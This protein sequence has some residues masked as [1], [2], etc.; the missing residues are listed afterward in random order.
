[1]KSDQHRLAVLPALLLLALTAAPAGAAPAASCADAAKS[2]Q[3]DFWIGEWD[4]IAGGGN[5]GIN[6]IEPILGGCVL[7]E[8]WR[9]AQGG[10]GTS[11]NFYNPDTGKWH[12]KWVW[13]GGKTLELEG[14]L[15]NGK[16]V[17]AGQQQ[18]ADGKTTRNR[19]TWTPNADGTVRQLWE[20]SADDG[21][22]W[23]V[24][25]DGLYKRRS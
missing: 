18:G 22:S 15:E 3:F 2:H 6:K 11:L 20:S 4:V 25:F 24:Q 17:M 10:E 19:I 8:N 7:Q 1:M 21:K 13:K 9:G 23:Q 16:M 5:A 14:G 12:Q